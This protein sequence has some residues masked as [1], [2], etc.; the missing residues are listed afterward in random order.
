LISTGTG[1]RCE[2]GFKA[3]AAAC[4][5]LQVPRNGHIDYSGNDW[6]C[7]ERYRRVGADCVAEQRP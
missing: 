6:A 4:A 7:D 5:A 2:R 1:W 3:E